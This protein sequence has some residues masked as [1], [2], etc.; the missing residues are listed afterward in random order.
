MLYDSLYDIAFLHKA[1]KKCNI[2][3]YEIEGTKP[4]GF[5]PSLNRENNFNLKLN[6][7]AKFDKADKYSLIKNLLIDNRHVA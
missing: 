1:L 5:K 3:H 2:L 7:I 4:V 6:E